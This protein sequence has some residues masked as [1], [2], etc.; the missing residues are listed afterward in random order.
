MG[1]GLA[2]VVI[3][4]VGVFLGFLV[5]QAK[6]AARKWR[7]V[8]AEGDRDALDELLDQTF[9]AW[10]MSRPPRGIAP[11][12]WRALHT[13]ALVAADKDRCRVSLLAD[14]DVR[15][16]SGQRIEAGSAM[17]VARRAAVRMVERL[18][19]EVPHVR[20]QD[21]QVDVYTDYRDAAGRTHSSCL[22]TTRASRQQVAEAPWGEAEAPEMLSEWHTLEAANGYAPD[23]DAGAV[24]E[25]PQG[26][27]LRVAEDK[28]R[29]AEE[30]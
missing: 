3:L 8:I 4:L 29:R 18:V 7:R 21:V 22:L 28:W 13:A 6:F 27:V 12:D 11:A 1:L 15:V 26:A 20:F 14:P 25:A 2:I 9:E 19:Y 10:R 5:V 30:G 24:I 23:P 17:D 16:V